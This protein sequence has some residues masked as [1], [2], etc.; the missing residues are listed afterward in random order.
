MGEVGLG[1]A[2]LGM[3]EVRELGGVAEEEDGRVVGDV[4]PVAFFG[5]EFDGES[6]RIAGQIVRATL[7]PD[8]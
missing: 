6:S 4:V 2:L 3:D 8:C 1:I 7:A 5:S